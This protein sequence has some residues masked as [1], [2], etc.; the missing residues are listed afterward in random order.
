MVIAIVF[1]GDGDYYGYV[2]NMQYQPICLY[3]YIY[4]YILGAAPTGGGT[5]QEGRK[6]GGAGRGWSGRRCKVVKTR[7]RKTERAGIRA[8]GSKEVRRGRFGERRVGGN[9]SLEAVF[10]GAS[11]SSGGVGG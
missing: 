1:W 9:K 8:R 4:M 10:I 3:I 7:A 2:F 6:L 11:L 5:E